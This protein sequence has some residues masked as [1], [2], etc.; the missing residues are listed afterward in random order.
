MFKKKKKLTNEVVN[1]IN[2]A[3]KEIK[4]KLLNI[5]TLFFI[6]SLFEANFFTIEKLNPNKR[7]GNK[8][9]IIQV[10]TIYLPYS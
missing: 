8:P 5:F 9:F 10:I 6:I 1:N 2:V 7:I 3:K 4:V